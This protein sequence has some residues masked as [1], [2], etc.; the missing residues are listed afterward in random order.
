VR[1]PAAA[2]AA[3]A[4]AGQEGPDGSRGGAGRAGVRRAQAC[5]PDAGARARARQPRVRLTS[6]GRRSLPPPRRPPAPKGEH[7]ALLDA[8]RAARLGAKA[9]AGKQAPEAKQKSERAGAEP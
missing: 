3:A 2:A 8:E 5:F 7:R 6:R 9:A 1:P 4:D